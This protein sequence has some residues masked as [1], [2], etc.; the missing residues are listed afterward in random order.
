[1]KRCPKCNRV[2]TDGA[3]KYCRVDGASLVN[4]STNLG[5]EARTVQPGLDASEVHTSILP[6]KT[7]ADTTTKK[8]AEPVNKRKGQT[9]KKT[10]I[11][12]AMGILLVAAFGI[13]SYLYFTRGS[14]R[15]ID[16]IAVIPFVN[17]SGNA[18][19]DYLSD[20]LTE[21][22]INTLTGLPNLNVKPRSSSF[23]YK[24]RESEAKTIGTELN[25]SAILNGRLVQR[26]DEITL[27]L[28][29]IDT[30]TENQIWGKRYTRKL[31]NL[32]TLHTEMARDVSE[33]LKRKLSGT[34]E[35]KLTKNYTENAE[36]YQLYLK[37]RFAWN[38]RT[39]KDNQRATEF[40]QQ[41]IALDP[42]YALA[43]AGLADSYAGA[44]VIANPDPVLRRERMARGREAALKALSLDNNLAEA[45]TALGTI[46]TT[47][48]YDFA[49]AER[50]YRR[51]IEINP[52]Y[53][54]AHYWYAQLL[55]RLGRF[56]EAFS[57]FK[58]T[59][60]LEPLNLT[61]QAN[62][63]G[64]LAWAGRREEA[65]TYL[66]KTL[67][68]DENF[69]PTL[70]NLTNTYELKGDYANVV[71]TRARIFE[72]SGDSESAA[73]GRAAFAKGGWN[74]YLRYLTSDRR[75]KYQSLYALAI[76]HAGL[77]EK[78]KAFEA[79]NRSYENRESLLQRLKVD[80]RLDPLRDDPRF[81]ELLKRMGFPE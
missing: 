41:A 76:G 31:T 36:A 65:I 44:A 34:A 55:S 51:A 80:P 11:A 28:A 77:G 20:G 49:G 19:V 15:Q 12:G 72:L 8:F 25:V 70:G 54:D 78:D 69:A 23:R 2:E 57:E 29:L 62:Y 67:Q 13:G 79:L 63:G 32:I 16:S 7:D 18:E 42:E 17:E 48:D 56:D 43:Y 53:A 38:K 61:Y 35:E 60:E 64:H 24:G 6:H 75:P 66:Q 4:E 59:L 33:S 71:Q 14:A 27:F 37:G 68:L 73:L 46:L 74:G 40:F 81:D 39:E 3:L 21:T 22:M 30:G 52:S 26:G 45:H 10:A 50:E 5:S 9:Q 47:F 1:M 58:R